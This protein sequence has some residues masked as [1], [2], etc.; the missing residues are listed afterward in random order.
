MVKVYKN[1]KEFV[2]DNQLFLDENKYMSSLFYID[3]KVLDE[4]TKKNYAVKVENSSGRMLAIKVEPYN[5]LLYGNEKCTEDMLNY[6]S[7]N[8]FEFDGV[9][10][11]TDIGD[12]ILKTHN[13][14]YKFIGMDFMEATTITE[15]SSEEVLVPSLDDL[16]EIYELANQFFIDCGL[17]DRP[18]KE[19]L[20]DNITNFRVLRKDNYIVS[21]AAYGY[22]TPDSYRITHVFTRKECRGNGYARKVVNS[23][24]N[25]ILQMGKIATLNVDQA[26]PI[27]NHL[28]SSLGFKKVFSQGIY[29]KINDL[30]KN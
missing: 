30:F 9:M 4:S 2:D 24:K 14:Y 11:P 18:S 3:A 17:P 22:N 29:L 6:L 20:K 16:D 28:Y 25:E 19:K 26:N 27:S 13:D 15:E 12:I 21:F 8:G 10:C 23:L 5:L 1:G 7:S